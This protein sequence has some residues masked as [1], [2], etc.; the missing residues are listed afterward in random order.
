MQGPRGIIDI[1]GVF[2]ALA[3]VG[4]TGNCL[5]EYERDY[6]DNAM[7]LAESFGYYRGVAEGVTVK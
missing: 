1:R 2:Q 7:G 4:F 5:I 3:D 6:A